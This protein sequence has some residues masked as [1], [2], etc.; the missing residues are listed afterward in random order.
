MYTP[1]IG[2]KRLTV[3]L[4]EYHTSSAVCTFLTAAQILHLPNALVPTVTQGA[5]S[6]LFLKYSE[7]DASQQL[8]KSIPFDKME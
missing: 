8:T 3:F 1:K 2:A 7:A 6:R 4:I 5:F